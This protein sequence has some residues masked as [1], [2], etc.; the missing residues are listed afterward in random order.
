MVEK[1]ITINGFTFNMADVNILLACGREKLSVSEIQKEIGMVYKNLLV[2]LKKLE[3]Y[4]LLK[5]I[6]KIKI[7]EF[8]W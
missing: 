8:Y 5:I 4:G 1:K 6:D 3:E 7:N 2:H